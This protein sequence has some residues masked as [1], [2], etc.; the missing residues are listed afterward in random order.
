MKR[1]KSLGEEKAVR[2][3]ISSGTEVVSFTGTVFEVAREELSGK[4]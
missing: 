3:G 2:K 4:I 1:G